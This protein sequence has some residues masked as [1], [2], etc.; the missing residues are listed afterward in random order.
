MTSRILRF[1]PPIVAGLMVGFAI[2]GARAEDSVD[3]LLRNPKHL[4]EVQAGCKVNAPWATDALCKTAGEAIRRRFRGQGVPYTPQH[5]DPFP[6][7][8]DPK[9]AHPSTTK[10][11][12]HHRPAAPRPNA[13]L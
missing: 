8:P 3:G 10:P 4:D 2:H 12:A 6:S 9:P 11:E 5:V 13:I 7:Q 1:G